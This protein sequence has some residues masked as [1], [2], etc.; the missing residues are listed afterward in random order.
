M[1]YN[2][3]KEDIDFLKIYYPTGD[4]D[5]IKER[6]PQLTETAIYRKMQRLGI[7]SNNLH[8]KTFDISR[9]RKNWTNEETK[10]IYENYENIPLEE[11][12]LLLPNRTINSI[13]AFAKRHNLV[14]YNH[15]NRNIWNDNEI[16]YIKNNWKL[17]PDKIIAENLNRTFR[18]VKAKRE[19]LGFYR[20]DMT[21]NTYPTLAKYLRGQNQKWKNDSMKNC[22][23]KC[24]LTGSK[25]FEI[26]HLY[27]VSNIINDILNIYEEYKD[28][29]FSEYT[30]Y[31]LSFLLGKFLE[32]QS[33]YPL[34]ECIDKKLH[35]LFHSMYGQ[36]YNTPEQWYKFKN[37]YMNGKYDKYV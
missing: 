32:E 37:D 23:Y 11:L 22:C 19:E 24:V 31:N 14:S 2:Y 36:Y 20:Q 17:V 13:K 26:H 8:R 4:W 9:I 34:G 30:D 35:V 33:K 21:T 18:A 6:F 25:D 29:E 15:K 7:K 10:I 16:N 12:L 27:G 28:K 3:T 5:K 1:R